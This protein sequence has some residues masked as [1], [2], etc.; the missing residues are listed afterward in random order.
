[1]YDINSIDE[2]VDVLG[3]DTVLSARLGISQPGVANWKVRGQIP[4]GWHMRLF[5]DVRKKGLTLNPDVFGM[6]AEEFG[7]LAETRRVHAV[8]NHI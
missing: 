5:A 1:M 3:G 7:P 2:L 4:P 8:A 6:T